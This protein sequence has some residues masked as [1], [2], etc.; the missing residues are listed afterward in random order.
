MKKLFQITPLLF[1][2][3]SYQTFAQ[4]TNELKQK[5]QQI[6]WTKNV[7]VG[8]AISGNNNKDTLS[9]HGND[10]FP[11]QSVFKFHIAIAVLSEI[12]KGNLSFNQ[13]IKIEKKDLI[14]NLYSPIRDKYPNGTIL[15]L[16]K[17]IEYTVSQ[18][19]NVGCDLL[20]KLIGGP[21]AVEEYFIK[22]GIKDVSIK[23]NEEVQ[24]A[25]WDLQFENWTTPK[26]ANEVLSTFYYNHAKLLSEKSY[27]FLWKTMKGTETGKA[28]LRGQLPEN[29]IVAHKTGSS[30]TNKNGL[31]AAVN[32][33]GIVFLP[34]GNHYF[35]S[36]F[37]TKSYENDETNEK[38][39]AD[40][41]KATWNYFLKNQK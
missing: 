22:N 24:Q 31:T 40:I 18:S 19:D 28:R 7:E 3:I 5:I 6:I 25:N 14:P 1:L 32:D 26:A 29:T 16:S 13:K 20:L 36:I 12:D 2:F 17:I 9:I 10:R 34:N 41:S 27:N 23:I 21:K 39:I 4:T 33:I 11:L 37:L 35:I 8:V 15:P 30:G 38:I